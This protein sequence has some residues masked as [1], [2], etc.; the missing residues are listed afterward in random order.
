MPK[1][2]VVIPTHNRPVMLKRAID[3]VL[4]QTYRDFEITVVDDGVQER[5]R[6]VVG[7]FS[8][9]RIRYIQHE[10]ERG[11]PAARNTGIKNSTGEL[12]AFL[13]DDDEWLPEK[14]E[15]QVNALEK[16][17]EAVLA[18]CGLTAVN[19]A[20]K[21]LYT[22]MRGL[23]GL[24]SP[25]SEI[26][27]KSFV[28]TSAIMARKSVLMNGFLFD[29][30]LT[31]NQ[32]WDLTLRLSRTMP[33]YSIN[34]LLVI[35]HIHGNQMGG[36]Q[37]LMGRING[38]HTFLRKHMADYKK[39]P[40]SLSLRYAEMAQLY[41][42]NDQRFMGLIYFAK[43]FLVHPERG[44]LIGGASLLG[45][46]N[47]KRTGKKIYKSTI[48]AKRANRKKMF[49]SLTKISS[50]LG[51]DKTATEELIRLGRKQGFMSQK[52]SFG[53]A[54]NFEVMMLY[55][56]IRA[57]KPTVIIETGVAS[58]R[59]SWAILQA[60]K[61]N[62]QGKLYSIDFPQFFKG[63]T[64]EMFLEETGHPEFRGFVPE[65]KM[66]GWLVPQELRP[67]WELILG[68]SSEKLPELL[69]KLGSIDIFYHDSDHS[70]E[71]MMFE[72]E[73]AWP[74]ILRGGF[75][76]SDDVKRNDAFMDFANKN[77]IKDYN[78]SFGFGL[79][80]KPFAHKNS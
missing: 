16:H 9:D 76:L 42:D 50:F 79:I 67:R 58:G 24:I 4:A 13:D 48:F 10:K 66:P 15:L 32:E 27:D 36:R 23:E 63:N 43:A 33:F 49:N 56:L 29:E 40:S 74:N 65:G 70:Y 34:K 11:A 30:N 71:N 62:N 18:F 61:D 17:S 53:H 28:W 51:I 54:G 31:K 12:I 8:D 35:L 2:S 72:F 75:L 25:F 64:P 69:E 22:R 68:K 41:K 39:Q 26:L 57:T 21:T 55:V 44:Y 45:L 7:S 78:L 46:G 19:D 20:G 5:A 77:N 73:T 60:L 37:N 1:V 47:L 52:F 3:S 38:Y 14:I 59:S 80:R 6:E